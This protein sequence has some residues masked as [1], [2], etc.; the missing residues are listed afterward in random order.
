L[1][2]LLLAVEQVEQEKVLA[3][4]PDSMLIDFSLSGDEGE[5]LFCGIIE[6]MDRRSTYNVYFFYFITYQSLFIFLFIYLFIYF[7]HGTDL[8]IYLLDLFQYLFTDSFIYLF[9]Y[10]TVT[11]YFN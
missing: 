1:E 3:E 2:E 9:I 6:Q 4:P 10:F 5:L 7:S 8:F 11:E